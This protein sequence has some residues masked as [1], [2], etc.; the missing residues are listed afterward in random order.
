MS[1]KN[2]NNKKAIINPTAPITVSKNTIEEP[3]PA[4]PVEKTTQEEV[5]S[6]I[7]VIDM[8]KF[9]ESTRQNTAGGM[10]PNRQVDLMKMMHETF[11]IDPD[12]AAKYG[13]VP[14]AVDKINRITAIGQVALLANEIA[15]AQNPFAIRMRKSQL[16]AILE[17]APLIG[18]EINEKLLP[19]PDKNQEI[20]VSSK[21]IK[22]SSAT[23]KQL[24]KENEVIDKK[25]PEMDVD[26][27]ATIEDMKTSLTYL[28]SQRQNVFSNIEKAIS[29]YVAWKVL[30]ATKSGNKDEVEKINTTSRTDILEEI[31]NI[32]KEA[33]IVIGGIGNFMY[34]ATAYSKSPISAFCHFRNTSFDRK[35]G[36]PTVDDQLIADL[37]KALI[38]W[39]T[40]IK[41]AENKKSIEAVTKNIEVL[42]TDETKNAAAI[43]DQTEKLETLNN[44]FSHFNDIIDYV[45]N[46][47]SDVADNLLDE[48][49]NKDA[50]AMKTYKSI[51]DS[52]YTGIDLATVDAVAL[53]H[54]I[55]QYAGII[56]NMFRDPGATIKTYNE[57]NIT[58]S[59]FKEETDS[60]TEEVSTD[61]KDSTPVTD[62]TPDKPKK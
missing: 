7:N 17:I 39:A 57:S 9:T 2:K 18:V 20:E 22:V 61:K 3:I 8:G 53:K 37:T 28:L 35:T 43:K 41:I 19:A 11:R 33:P 23:K 31:I 38:I 60:K 4:A 25:E 14:D 49:S 5:K 47:S 32:V 50:A 54:N 13:M 10:D 44:N 24:K 55:Q 1:K 34:T 56:T 16:E 58:E 62:V 51:L 42:K 6:P 59:I 45:K 36:T 21:A 40:D 48:V 46:P 30:N 27:I 12:A 26:K 29:L 15:F 52:Y